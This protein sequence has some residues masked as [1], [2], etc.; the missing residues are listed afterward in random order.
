M[1]LDP[2][3]VPQK[4]TPPAS[5]QSQP[6]QHLA[7]RS[8]ADPGRPARAGAD[9]GVNPAVAGGADPSRAVYP[10]HATP[11][12]DTSRASQGSS[13]APQDSSRP[14]EGHGPAG[15]GDSRPAGSPR[16]AGTADARAA[17]PARSLVADGEREALERRIQHAMTDFVDDPRRAVQEA[18]G[19]MEEVAER[20]T[21]A[22]AEQRRKLR[23]AWDGG[24]RAADTEQLRVTLREYRD[25]T[26]RLLRL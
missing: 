17:T 10:V 2:A 22:L 26:D 4:G 6:V 14:A 12:Q 8:S 5:G 18:A 7:G 21:S 11:P 1:S 16:S 19:T 25:M 15:A 23:T 24:D 9:G 13:H 20:L 3:Q